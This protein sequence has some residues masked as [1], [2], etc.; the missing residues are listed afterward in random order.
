MIFLATHHAVRSHIFDAKSLYQANET[1]VE[2]T[3]ITASTGL[4]ETIFQTLF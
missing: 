4:A 3:H 2:A 1:I